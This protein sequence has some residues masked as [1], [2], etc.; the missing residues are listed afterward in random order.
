MRLTA[1]EEGV[2]IGGRPH[3]GYG[4]FGLR[5]QPVKSSARSRAS[6]TR[7]AL[8]PR[9][10]WLDYSGVFA[11]GKDPTGLAIFEHVANP[12]YRANSKKY[13]DLNYVM[14]AFPGERGA[15]FKGQAARA[16]PSAVDT[17]AW[18]ASKLA[19]VWAAFA[20][21]PKAGMTEK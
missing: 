1:L 10:S 11:G 20:N 6:L 2:A 18:R 16:P 9:R 8:S 21:P 3:G 17:K 4:G 5:A 19:T 13:P 12:L 7:P 14:P 15:A